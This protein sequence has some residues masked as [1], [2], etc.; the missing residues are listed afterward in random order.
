VTLRDTS[1][2]MDPRR[3]ELS[4]EEKGA[5]AARVVASERKRL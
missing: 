3:P 1:L 2:P 5:I 4:T